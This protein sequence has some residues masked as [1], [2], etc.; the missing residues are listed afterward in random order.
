MAE[1]RLSVPA[2]AQIYE[3]LDWSQENFGDISRE[4]YAA[5]L[6][7]AMK[8]VAD[9]PNQKAVSWKRVAQRRIAACATAN[10]S[11]G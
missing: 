6:V 4:R 5:L 10:R 11:G 1:Y 3:I 8:D 7:T 2:E 9:D